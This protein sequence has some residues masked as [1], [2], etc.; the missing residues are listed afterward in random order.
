MKQRR[1]STGYFF[2]IIL[3][4]LFVKLWIFDFIYVS[5]PSMKPTL[6]HGT[7]AIEYK[8]A[9]G[10]PVPFMNSYLVRWAKPGTGDIVIYPWMDRYVVK[11]CV[12]TEGLPLVFSVEN[13]YSILIGGRAVPLTEAQYQKLKS[14]KE[15]PEGMIFALGDNMA[16]SRD[17]REYGFVSLDSIR[18][19]ILWK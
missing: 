10:I 4:L 5:G 7:F 8:L 19:K 14:A 9:W 3:V 2:L 1:N 15:V 18:G 17:S 11:R 6:P 16:E 13:G 12:A